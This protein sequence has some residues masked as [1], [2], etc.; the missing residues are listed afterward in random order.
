MKRIT[1]S[2]FIILSSAIA[3]LFVL[4][5]CG[6][7][8]QIDSKWRTKEVIIDGKN[9]EWEGGVY[10]KDLNAVVNIYNDSQNLYLGIISPDKQLAKKIMMNGLTVWIDRT[11]SDDKNFGVHFPIGMFNQDAPAA[12]GMKEAEEKENPD[13]ND[14][15]EERMRQPP[16]TMKDEMFDRG[17]TEYEIL[18]SGGKLESRIQS[19]EKNGIEVKMGHDE[20]K[21]LYELK[22]PLK[23]YG[24]I[25]YAIGADTGQVVSIGLSTGEVDLDKIKKKMGGPKKKATDDQQDDEGSAMGQ[26]GMGGGRPH[27]GGRGGGGMQGGMDS[28]KA[29]SLWFKTKISSAK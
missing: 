13:K 1:N 29:I 20:D 17:L 15:G 12:F 9:T 7:S 19:V 21:I 11:G 25:P 16:P 3:A 5:G 4:M 23:I 8:L 22:M 24:D 6:S 18:V 28:Q 10:L 27:G 14:D 2:R 26:G